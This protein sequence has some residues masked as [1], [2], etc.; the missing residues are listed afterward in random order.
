MNSVKIFWPS[1]AE[2][3]SGSRSRKVDSGIRKNKIIFF[4][5]KDLAGFA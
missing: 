3:G 1:A 5:T 2:A 4:P